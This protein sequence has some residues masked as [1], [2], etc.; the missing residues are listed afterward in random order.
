M[1]PQSDLMKGWVAQEWGVVRTACRKQGGMGQRQGLCR[2]RWGAILW[3]LLWEVLLWLFW[4]SEC[5]A[6]SLVALWGDG[7][8]GSRQR[9]EGV[10]TVGLSHSWQPFEM[11]SAHRGPPGKKVVGDSSMQPVRGWKSVKVPF[12]HPSSERHL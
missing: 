3:R 12:T 4:L 5:Q 8:R 11:G 7:G 6:S 2:G 9:V 1:A 10:R